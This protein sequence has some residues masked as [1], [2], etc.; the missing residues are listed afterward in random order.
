[1]P[2]WILG[3]LS[4]VLLASFASTPATRAPATTGIRSLAWLAGSWGHVEGESRAEE[5]WTVPAGGTM[6]A[7]GRQVKGE[8]TVFFEFLRIEE[9]ANGALV[10]VAM[11][12][13]KRA[14]EFTL[15]KQGE[16]D[17]LFENPAHDSPKR[18]SYRVEKDE[19]VTRVDDGPADKGG[20]EMRYARVK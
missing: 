4:V 9:R 17:A 10:Y 2:R 12:L 6:L 18:I 13:G 3:T 5:N 14:T 19:L 20:F 16:S 15:T 7:T 11:P 8:K 1:M